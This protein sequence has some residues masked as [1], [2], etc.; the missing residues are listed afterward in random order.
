MITVWC[1]PMH[2]PLMTWEKQ[3]RVATQMEDQNELSGF[4]LWCCPTLATAAI[5]RVDRWWT[6]VE[7][8]SQSLFQLLPKC[9]L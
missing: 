6:Q 3:W 7:D 5:W 4:S 1:V 9:T 2:L 8:L